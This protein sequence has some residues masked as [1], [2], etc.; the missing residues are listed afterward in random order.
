MKQNITSADINNCAE[1]KPGVAVDIAD[2]EKVSPTL[3]AEQTEDLN[4]NPN[5][6]DAAGAE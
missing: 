5:N 1:L 4:N 2:D 3:V 6:T